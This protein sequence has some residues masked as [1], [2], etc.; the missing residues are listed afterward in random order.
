MNI[1]DYLRD[2]DLTILRKQKLTKLKNMYATNNKKY[3]S[4]VD[5]DKLL[6]NPIINS[7]S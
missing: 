4:I 5:K 7:F 3:R 2:D 6:H 1:P